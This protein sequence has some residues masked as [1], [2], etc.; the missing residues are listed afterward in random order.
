MDNKF[1][2]LPVLLDEVLAGLDIRPDGTYI[3]G[4]C[5]GGGHSSE[6]A[7]KLSG[8]TLLGIDRDPDAVKAASERLAP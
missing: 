1:Y 4:T 5:G 2:H 8:G 6:I 3:D 7:K